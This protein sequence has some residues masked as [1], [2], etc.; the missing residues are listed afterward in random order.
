MRLRKANG[1]WAL[2][3]DVRRRHDPTMDK[4]FESYEMIA[5][6]WHSFKKI[7]YESFW[8]DGPNK[9]WFLGWLTIHR[10]TGHN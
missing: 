8:Y 5:W 7:A 2:E 1:V 4:V 9:V 10:C 6:D 3:W